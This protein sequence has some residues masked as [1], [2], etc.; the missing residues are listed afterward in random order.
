MKRTGVD[1]MITIFRQYSEKNW[2]FILKT[3]VTIRNWQNLT[4]LHICKQKNPSFYSPI[5]WGENIF[6]IITSVT[7]RKTLVTHSLRRFEP[8]PSEKVL[9][10]LT[11]NL[12]LGP[13]LRLLKYF[14]PKIWQKYWL[15]LLKL[16]K[17]F[18]KF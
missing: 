15:Y 13:M 7:D 2:T 17:V 8:S 11:T 14:R 10:D 6:K 12:N 5:F 4:V 18:V 3:N 16:L 9:R 1:V